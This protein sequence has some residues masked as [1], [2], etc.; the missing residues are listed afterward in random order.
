DGTKKF[1]EGHYILRDSST[2]GFNLSAYDSTRPLLI[3][4]V[5]SYST[6][7]GGSGNEEILGIAVDPA[8]NAYVTGS[9]LSANFPTSN[10]LQASAGGNGDA[11]IAKFDPSGNLIYSTYVGGSGGEDGFGIAI[12]SSGNAYVTGDTSSTNFPTVKALQP[13]S[14]GSI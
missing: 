9:T 5:L 8:G 7:L 1:I 6:Y 11:F 2:V 3:D 12:D 10:P 4:P 14:G 13:S